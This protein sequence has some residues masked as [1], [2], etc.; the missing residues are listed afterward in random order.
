[1]FS[2]K[3]NTVKLH[4]WLNYWNGKKTNL[5]N[6]NFTTG[7]QLPIISPFPIFFINYSFYY[8]ISLT[9]FIVQFI[10]K[11]L[12]GIKTVFFKKAWTYKGFGWQIINLVACSMSPIL[13][14]SCIFRQWEIRHFSI[15]LCLVTA[16]YDCTPRLWGWLRTTSTNLLSIGKI[17]LFYS[18]VAWL[19]FSF[20]NCR[21]FATA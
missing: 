8:C 16:I 2:A 11:F 1:M 14:N 19:S 3:T 15:I 21:Y 7:L 10:S 5:L 20:I 4:N 18:H 9:V 17:I 13:M 6:M 12:A